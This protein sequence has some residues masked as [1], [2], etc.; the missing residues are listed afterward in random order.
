MKR[1]A[2]KPKRRDNGYLRPALVTEIPAPTVE[3][4]RRRMLVL[5]S[6]E[7][8]AYQSRVPD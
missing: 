8:F 6:L 2:S 3:E 4:A 7:R 1:S 5:R